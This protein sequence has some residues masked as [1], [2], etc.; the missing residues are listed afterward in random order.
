MSS[1]PSYRSKPA[2]YG[3]TDKRDSTEP[4]QNVN[5]SVKVSTVKQSNAQSQL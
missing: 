5:F 3:S 1:M 4:G 2:I